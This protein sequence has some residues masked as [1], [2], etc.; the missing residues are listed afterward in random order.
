MKKILFCFI[1]FII[2]SPINHVFAEYDFNSQEFKEVIEQLD[3]QGHSN[4]DYATCSVKRMYY[5]EVLSMLNDG[6][7]PKEILQY[8]VDEYGQAALKEP[9]KDKNGLIAWGMPIIGLLAG[10]A[11]VFTWLRK[12]KNGKGEDHPLDKV[13]VWESETEKEIA[14][15]LFDEE[16]RKHF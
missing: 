3:M 16:R 9:S 7:K 10:G 15:K 6:M 12:I 2:V 4:D 1:F 5:D 8:Y 13:Q 11:I 14:E